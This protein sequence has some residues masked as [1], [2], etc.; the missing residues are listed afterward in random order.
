MSRNHI[1]KVKNSKN[2]YTIKKNKRAFKIKPIY[3]TIIIGVSVVIFSAFLSA[4]LSSLDKT[5]IAQEAE[6]N[7]LK[8]TKQSL[9]GEVKGIKSSQEIQEEA[10]YKLGMVYPQENQIV[11]VD[12]SK[13]KINK[14]VNNNVFLSPIISVL[15][16]FTK[17]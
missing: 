14:D 4:Q 13:N 11:Y 15:K 5:I 16:S 3:L 17:N 12:V 2:K 1:K 10:M 8:K 6:I 7:E 9:E